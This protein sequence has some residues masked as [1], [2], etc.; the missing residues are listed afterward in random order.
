MRGLE[1]R[2]TGFCQKHYDILGGWTG[3]RVEHRTEPG[4]RLG[5]LQEAWGQRAGPWEVGRG[6]PVPLCFL[7][8]TGSLPF[9]LVYPESPLED[10]SSSLVWD[11]ECWEQGRVMGSRF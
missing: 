7:E 9:L 4:D 5:G 10:S 8:A 6:N 2:W 3:Q 1:G 11:S